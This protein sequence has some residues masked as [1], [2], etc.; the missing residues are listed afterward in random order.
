MVDPEST[1]DDQQQRQ[2]LL[3]QEQGVQAVDV[4]TGSALATQELHSW[5]EQLGLPLCDLYGL[6][7][8]VPGL[9]NVP[10]A[11][12]F[13]SVGK[14]SK[15]LQSKLSP[16]GEILLKADHLMK[17]YYKNKEKTDETI[18]DGWLYTGDRAAVDEQG[19]YSIIGRTKEIFKTFNNLLYISVKI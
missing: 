3:S 8:C 5:F 4:T 15:N 7:E 10:T 13:G 9:N 18:I 1:V 11:R 17:G 12:K 16:S 6:S 14:P 19:F 2:S